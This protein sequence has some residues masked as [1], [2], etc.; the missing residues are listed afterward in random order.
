MSTVG[1]DDRSLPPPIIPSAEY[2]TKVMHVESLMA[3]HI[4]NTFLILSVATA[5]TGTLLSLRHLPGRV[6]IA[7]A[8]GACSLALSASYGAFARSR[9]I[10]LWQSIVGHGDRDA[11][12]LTLP[13]TWLTLAPLISS[14]VFTGLGVAVVIA[15]I[16]M[17]R[18]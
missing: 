9:I 11:G 1:D 17:R 18:R 7:A 5:V 3:S 14:L 10:V 12:E 8:F 15:S 13:P 2:A 4:R 6:Y 16:W